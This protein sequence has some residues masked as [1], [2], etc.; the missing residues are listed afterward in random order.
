MRALAAKNAGV[1]GSALGACG[2]NGH[3]RDS[4][5]ND[6]L[7]DGSGCGE[8]RSLNGGDG[9]DHQAVSGL[10]TAN[11]ETGGGSAEG[12]ATTATAAGVAFATTAAVEA[13]AA[14]PGWNGSTPTA[15]ESTIASTGTAASSG[16]VNE[17]RASRTTTS[18]AHASIGE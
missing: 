17:R 3:L 12:A 6:I 8:E 4:R 14:S 5:G 1:T 9:D 2:I 10:R 18:E 13:A 7:L 11:R 15:A 16:T